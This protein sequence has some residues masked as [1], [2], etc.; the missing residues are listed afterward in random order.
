MTTQLGSYVKSILPEPH[1]ILGLKMRPF[2]LGHLFLMERFECGYASIDPSYQRSYIDLLLSLAICCR[3]YEEFLEFMED[4]KEF[5]RWTKEWGKKMAKYLKQ[6]KDFDPLTPMIQ[7]EK[8]VKD[9]IAIPKYWETRETDLSDRSGAHWSQ[10]VFVVMLSE[11]NYTRTEALNMPL[12]QALGECFK[13]AENK[14]ALTL[15]NDDELQMIEA[16]EAKV[17]V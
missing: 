8:Y 5:N 6:N 15:M 17:N 4:K 13:M 12:S 2:C 14:G 3:T 9:G 1:V 16:A 10:N 11:L 7:F